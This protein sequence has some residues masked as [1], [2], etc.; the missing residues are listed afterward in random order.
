MLTKAMLETQSYRVLAVSSPAEA[1]AVHEP[2]DLL[3]TDVVMPGMSGVELARRLAAA[4][5][6]SPVLFTSGYSAAVVDDGAAL[7]GRLLEK[8]F[9]LEQLAFHVR[10]AIEAGAVAVPG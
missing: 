9:T 1:L 8:P 6:G 5:R 2:W 10:E 7:P 4:G 3:L